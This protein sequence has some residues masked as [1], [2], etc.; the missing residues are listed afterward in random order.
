MKSIR[1][2]LVFVLLL[3]SGGANAQNTDRFWA[4]G[5]SAGID[6]KNLSNPQPGNSILR[7]RGRRK[8]HGW[9]GESDFTNSQYRMKNLPPRNLNFNHALLHPIDPS[10]LSQPA[11]LDSGK[12]LGHCGHVGAAPV[13]D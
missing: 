13:R 9:R 2:L 12:R 4:F 7:S 8:L 11:S 10:S 1:S 5:D 6:F 3:M